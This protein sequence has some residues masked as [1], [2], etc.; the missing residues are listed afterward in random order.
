[1]SEPF[2]IG[3]FVGAFVCP[4]VNDDGGATGPFV[5]KGGGAVGGG[6]LCAKKLETAGLDGGGPEGVGAGLWAAETGAAEKENEGAGTARVG[7]FSGLP[8]VS[9]ERVS[10]DDVGILKSEGVLVE[11]AT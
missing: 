9:L 5:F 8:L 6:A 11:L 1:M 3:A 4:N 2:A 10:E 7:L